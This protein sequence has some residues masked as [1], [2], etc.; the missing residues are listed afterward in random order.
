MGVIHS[1]SA[2][3]RYCGKF[4]AD[5]SSFIMSGRKGQS[6]E[7]VYKGEN[8]Q[9]SQ[10]TCYSDGAY[11]YSNPVS[12]GPNTTYYNT[13]KGHAFYENKGGSY[14]SGGQPYKTH[15]NY[16]QGTSNNF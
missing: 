5:D 4:T 6:R 15:Y 13:G 7:V 16:N 9:G 14:A 8:S 3:T 10:Y 12:D 2:T 1:V 11:R